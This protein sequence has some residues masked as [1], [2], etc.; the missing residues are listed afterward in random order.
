M[1]GYDT[2]T[3]EIFGCKEKS[4]TWWHEKGH[5]ELHKLNWWKELEM[6]NGYLLLFV[7]AFIT[8]Q[9]FNIARFL[10]LIYLT[11]L[12]EDEVI[13][14]SYCLKHKFEWIK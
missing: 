8:T 6:Y 4:M 9:Q 13:A 14:W 7:I 5:L 10:F 3:E 1:A 2:K 12:I 11:I